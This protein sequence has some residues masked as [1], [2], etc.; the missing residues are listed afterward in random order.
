MEGDLIV[1]MLAFSA[2]KA[3]NQE[4]WMLLDLGPSLL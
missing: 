2:S 3:I 4:I 1:S